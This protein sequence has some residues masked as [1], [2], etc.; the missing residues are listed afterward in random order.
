[1]PWLVEVMMSGLEYRV[2]VGVDMVTYG[3]G[4]KITELNH[5]PMVFLI[6]EP[7]SFFKDMKPN[8]TEPFGSSLVWFGLILILFFKFLDLH[9]IN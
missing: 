4:S 3:S 9:H 6:M 2:W 8:W 7:N 5:E 1:M